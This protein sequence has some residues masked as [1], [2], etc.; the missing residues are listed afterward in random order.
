MTSLETLF[1]ESNRTGLS[2]TLNDYFKAWSDLGTNKT[3]VYQG[4]ANSW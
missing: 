1:N 2:S 4:Y 3:G